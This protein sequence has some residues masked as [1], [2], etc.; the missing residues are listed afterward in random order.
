MSAHHGGP[1]IMTDTD[2]F[3]VRICGCGVVHLSF[4][5]AVINVS[6]ETAIAITETLKEVSTDLRN[7]LQCHDPMNA[8][9]ATID[10][11]SNVVYG[12]FPNS[13]L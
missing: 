12:R 4:G 2:Q 8:D 5:V 13:S 7:R 6:I 9:Q 3:Y 1:C 10:P 11:A